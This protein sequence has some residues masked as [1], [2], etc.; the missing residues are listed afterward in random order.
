M[1]GIDFFSDIRGT[2]SIYF[3]YIT[4]TYIDFL[5]ETPSLPCCRPD[6]YILPKP[7]Q[8]IATLN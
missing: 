1:I 7:Y 8:F 3:K 2:L 5:D 4:S 6:N